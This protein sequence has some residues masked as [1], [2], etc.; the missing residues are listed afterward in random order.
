MSVKTSVYEDDSTQVFWQDEQKVTVPQ[1][2]ASVHLAEKALPQVKRWTLNDPK[3][4][5]IETVLFTEDGKEVDRF[6]THTGF[7]TVKVTPEGFYLNGKK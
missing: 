4:Y 3:L 1:G 6:E 2:A 5:R 7:R